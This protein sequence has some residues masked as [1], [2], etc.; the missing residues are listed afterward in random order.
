MPPRDL[1]VPLEWSVGS[2]ESRVCE[3]GCSRAQLRVISVST[4]TRVW[5]ETLPTMTFV[6]LN[7][8]TADAVDLDPTLRRC[9][10]F[11]KRDGYGGMKIVN[12]YAYRTPSPKVMLAVRARSAP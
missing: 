12:L 1:L 2:A 8:S 7:P 4:P 5:D 9:V 6:L 3:T 10:N 11:S